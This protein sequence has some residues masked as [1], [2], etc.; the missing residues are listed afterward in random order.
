MCPTRCPASLC[1]VIPSWRDG[2]ALRYV[3]VSGRL[4]DDIA[5]SLLGP[6]DVIERGCAASPA[7]YLFPFPYHNSLNKA[8]ATASWAS[9][10]L[11]VSIRLCG[12]GSPVIG[13]HL[14]KRSIRRRHAPPV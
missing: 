5:R 13:E 11:L 2:A 12:H 3:T 14:L 6:C 9:P 7:R 4:E 10:D 8:N 1:T